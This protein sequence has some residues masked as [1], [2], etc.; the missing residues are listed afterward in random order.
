MLTDYFRNINLDAGAVFKE[1]FKPL[2]ENFDEVDRK[3]DNLAKSYTQ[4]PCHFK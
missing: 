2:E 1:A 3:L 4:A